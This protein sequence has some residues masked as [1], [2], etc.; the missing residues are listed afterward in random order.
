MFREFHKYPNELPDI[1]TRISQCINDTKDAVLEYVDENSDVQNEVFVD[2]APEHLPPTLATY[3]VERMHR[4]PLGYIAAAA[5]SFVASRLV[6]SEGINFCE[7]LP[8]D[9]LAQIA[10]DF[11]QAQRKTRV[12][13][14][15]VLT[16][17]GLDDINRDAIV[18]LLDRG[19]ARASLDL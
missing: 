12:A 6:Y 2:L 13:V 15:A 17:P 3:A 1:S 18:R 7:T 14:S 10:L 19:G 4:L 5:A 11:V 16:A 8:K 9:R